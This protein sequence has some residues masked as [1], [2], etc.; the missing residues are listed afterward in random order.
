MIKRFFGKEWA[1]PLFDFYC[2]KLFTFVVGGERVAKGRGI[3]GI[4]KE[5]GERIANELGY[6]LVDVEYVK[7]NDYF[8]LRVYIDKKG[9]INLD[10]CQIMTEKLSE[11]LDR[12]D[13]TNEAYFLEVSSP[14]LDRPLKTD[15]DYERNL[16]KEVELKLYKSF[17]NRKKLE[18][19]LRAYNEEDFEIEMEDGEI[20]A[21]PREIVSLMRLV[22]KF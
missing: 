14:G 10:D 19:F 22:I 3:V 16:G 1:C 15:K 12:E 11:L 20:L 7:E 8:F 9:G 21:I 18:G 17:N 5:N 13:P 2:R 6:D 4:T